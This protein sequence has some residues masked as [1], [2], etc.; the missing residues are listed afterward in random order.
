MGG[1]KSQAREFA[2]YPKFRANYVR[3]FDRMLIA[4]QEAGLENKISWQ[5]GED[6][7]RWWT[8][9]QVDQIRLDDIYDL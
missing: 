9:E 4:R 7:M 5:S 3:A 2:L 6:V 8:G 1:Y